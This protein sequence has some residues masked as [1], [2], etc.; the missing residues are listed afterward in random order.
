MYKGK[1]YVLRMGMGNGIYLYS[2][3]KYD[4]NPATL[5]DPRTNTIIPDYSISLTAS[6]ESY[7]GKPLT[8]TDDWD[9]YREIKDHLKKQFAKY[10][11]D[12]S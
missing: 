3:S 12:F 4:Y 1:P 9:L 5:I 6:F 2:T 7:D 11:I 10:E 8:A